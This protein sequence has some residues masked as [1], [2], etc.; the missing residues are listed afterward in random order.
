MITKDIYPEIAAT[1]RI[2]TMQVERSIRS[3]IEK[4]YDRGNMQNW[5]RYVPPEAD[6]SIRCPSN[7][8]FVYTLAAKLSLAEKGKNR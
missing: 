7:G 6:G 1:F 3:C 2:S 5:A 4:A 8:A